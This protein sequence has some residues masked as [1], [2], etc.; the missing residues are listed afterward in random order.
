[1]SLQRR[2]LPRPHAP[3][4]RPQ[5]RRHQPLYAETGGAFET[6]GDGAVE[7]FDLNAGGEV[8]GDRSESPSVC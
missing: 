5:P 3:R 8:M 7:E 1:M 2:P 4:Q 6:V